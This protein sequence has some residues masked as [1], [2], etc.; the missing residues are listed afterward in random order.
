MGGHTLRQDLTQQV[1][2]QVMR[3]VVGEVKIGEV[4]TDYCQAICPYIGSFFEKWIDHAFP[5]LRLDRLLLNL[6]FKCLRTDDFA[7]KHLPAHPLANEWSESG[8]IA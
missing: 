1:F 3:E 5:S 7:L 4:V 8:V 2:K 6:T